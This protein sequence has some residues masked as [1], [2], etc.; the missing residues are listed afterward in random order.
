MLTA[1]G[2]QTVRLWDVET[3]TLKTVFGGGHSGT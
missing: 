2:D 1:S 3:K